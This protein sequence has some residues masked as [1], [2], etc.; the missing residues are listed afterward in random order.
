MFNYES[1]SDPIQRPRYTGLSTFMRSP[2]RED[3]DGVEVG[4]VGVLKMC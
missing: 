3:V 2:H 1:F 4:L